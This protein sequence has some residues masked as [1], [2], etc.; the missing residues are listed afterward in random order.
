MVTIIITCVILGIL[1]TKSDD[2]EQQSLNKILRYVSVYYIYIHVHV[3][4]YKYMYMYIYTYIHVH[5]YI[6][7]YIHFFNSHQN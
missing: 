4:T 3:H 5:K 1:R 2:V 7:T 6:H